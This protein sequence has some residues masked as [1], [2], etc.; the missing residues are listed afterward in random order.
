MQLPGRPPE[1]LDLYIREVDPSSNSS[2]SLYVDPAGSEIG[3]GLENDP[4]PTI[5]AAVELANKMLPLGFSTTIN[6]PDGTHS[7]SSIPS[8][9]LS[10][11]AVVY[12]S[13]IYAGDRS[14]Q[15]GSNLFGSLVIKGASKTGT[16]IQT[17]ADYTYGIYCTQVPN[18]AIST[19]TI[20]SDGTNAASSLI[21]AH[22]GCY[23]QTYDVVV[24]GRSTATQCVVAESGGICEI[25]G[26]SEIKD[27]E[28]GLIAFDESLIVAS[29][30]T[31]V[32]GCSSSQIGGRGTITLNNTVDVQDVVAIDGLT[33][34]AR[35]TDASNRVTIQSNI[36]ANNCDIYSTFADWSGTLTAQMCEVDMNESAWSD[37]WIIRGGSINLRGSS[38]SYISP[39]V[40]ST[41][42]NPLQLLA[43]AQFYSNST[44]DIAGSGSTTSAIRNVG[45]QAITA[46]TTTIQYQAA[47]GSDS[48][49]EITADG[50]YTGCLLPATSND[51]SLPPN[52]GDRLTLIY[53]GANSVALVDGSTA[54]IASGGV[55]LGLGAGNY[56]G[57]T[58]VWASDRL[59]RESSRSGAN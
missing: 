9:D 30:T 3:T 38:T 24:D 53:R 35:G 7:L 37:A 47:S 59:W 11:P 18:V 52:V 45:T 20:Q 16:I 51:L 5:Q 50:A 55:T 36:T 22:R 8:S 29:N 23:V 48:L 54:D 31:T 58:F 41:A 42:V 14:Y 10:R 40:A 4:V 33:L 15:S 44:A 34:V 49:T 13:D 21:T 12:I 25:T 56:S 26:A 6:I 39:A 19:L 57:I 27:A 2:V 46:D 17:S 28:S 1:K 43:D 32:S